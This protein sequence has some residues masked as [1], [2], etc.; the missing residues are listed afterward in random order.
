MA[1]K[2]KISCPQGRKRR[3]DCDGCPIQMCRCRSPNSPWCPTQQEISL[4][5]S[6]I[7]ATWS[8]RVRQTRSRA[9]DRGSSPLHWTVPE[10]P[11]PELPTPDTSEMWWY[12]L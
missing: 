4:L 1:R 7:Q 9:L 12:L 5:C 3:K 6:Q 11:H 10:L 8:E 2:P